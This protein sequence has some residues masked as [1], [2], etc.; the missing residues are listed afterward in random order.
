VCAGGRR[1]RGIVSWCNCP[2]LG[3][4]AD[5]KKEESIAAPEAVEVCEPKGDLTATPDTLHG[6][7]QNGDDRR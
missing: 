5:E 4:S 6:P 1:R 2:T 7:C 3:D